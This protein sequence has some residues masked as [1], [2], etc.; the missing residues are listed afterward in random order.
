MAN[1]EVAVIV[2]DVHLA[3]VEDLFISTDIEISKQ[4]SSK[5]QDTV[6]LHISGIGCRGDLR[7]EVILDHLRQQGISYSYVW[8][9]P[10]CNQRGECHYRSNGKEE[11]Y[12]SWMDYEKNV[13]NIE[14]VRQAVAQGDN[15]ILELLEATE[16]QYTPWGW[17]EVA[18]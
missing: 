10:N 13:V 15:A 8:R 17:S 9:E 6:T 14:E 3:K 11:Q 7:L 4:E 1:I 12:L 16:N 5:A 2:R 18:A